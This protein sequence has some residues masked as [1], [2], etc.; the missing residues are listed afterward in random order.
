MMVVFVKYLADDEKS[1]RSEVGGSVVGLEI[2]LAPPVAKAVDHTDSPERDPQHVQCPHRDAQHAEQCDI[3]RQHEHRAEGGI[4]GV[5]MALDPVVRTALAVLLDR[6]TIGTRCAI[7]LH[8][9]AHNR[10]QAEHLRAVRSEEHTSEL[11][12]LMRISYAVFCL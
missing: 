12:S 6:L 4:R 1:P 2:A 5:Q 7:Q 8:A 10:A 3:D 9:V 11:Q